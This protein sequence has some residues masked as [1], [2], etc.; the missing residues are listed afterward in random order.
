MLLDVHRVAPALGAVAGIKPLAAASAL[1]PETLVS[2]GTVISPVGRASNGDTVLSMKIQYD[3]G[4]ELNVE[5]HYGELEVWPLLPGQL[6]TVELKPHRRF[7]VGLGRRGKGGTIQVT[8]GLMGLV[9]DARGRPLR[10]P[11]N[12]EAR[13][14]LLRR[15]IWDV[16]G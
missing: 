8:G 4:S 1:S 13:R 7:D 9:V 6:A 3:D 5:A 11:E 16:G 12:A 14:A 10:L 2:L 15:W